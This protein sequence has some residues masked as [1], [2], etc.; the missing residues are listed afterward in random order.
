[1]R[2]ES[3]GGEPGCWHQR[4]ENEQDTRRQM[5]E[6]HRVDETDATGEPSR[7]QQRD[8][9][10]QGH[11]KEEHSELAWIETPA[12]EEPVR[13]N[14]LDNEAA[15]ECVETEERTE[16]GD[17]AGRAMDTEETPLPLDTCRLH[18]VGEAQKDREVKETD[19]GVEDEEGTVRVRAGEAERREGPNHPR[20]ERARGLRDVGDEGVD[21][22][23]PRAALARSC[24]REDRLLDGEERADLGARRRDGSGECPEEEQREA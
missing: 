9:G 16:P 15:R 7:G 1:P 4:N 3:R 13:D 10:D 5:C 19:D 11:E 18:F 23:E 14:R 22:E 2:K 17:G 20:E 21:G 12:D 6:D 8:A 24:L